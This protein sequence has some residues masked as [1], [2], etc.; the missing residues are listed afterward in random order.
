MAGYVCDVVLCQDKFVD[1]FCWFSS[2]LCLLDGLIYLYA[3]C[4]DYM[5]RKTQFVNR[6][7]SID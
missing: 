2:V 1:G 6:V 7:V 4:M 3:P 5:E